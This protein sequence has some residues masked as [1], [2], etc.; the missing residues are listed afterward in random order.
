MPRLFC[1]LL[2]GSLVGNAAHAAGHN[3]QHTPKAYTHTTSAVVH[4]GPTTEILNTQ[5]LANAQRLVPTALPVPPAALPDGTIARGTG[6]LAPELL[7]APVYNPA[8]RR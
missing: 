6:V 2:L 7:E 4:N 3:P 1:L 5:S 8:D